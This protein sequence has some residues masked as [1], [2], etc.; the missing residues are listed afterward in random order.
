MEL[1]K[2]SLDGIKITPI[3]RAIWTFSTDFGKSEIN[4]IGVEEDIIH[5]VHS[6]AKY[7]WPNLKFKE[8]KDDENSEFSP[9]VFFE[10]G[11]REED[12]KFY[13]LLESNDIEALHSYLEKADTETIKERIS[14]TIRRPYMADLRSN[15]TYLIKEINESSDIKK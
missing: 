13:S 10:Y 2:L 8:L 14:L 6:Y 3:K 11:D 12:N 15:N 9:Y 1:E 7:H 5:F 4:L